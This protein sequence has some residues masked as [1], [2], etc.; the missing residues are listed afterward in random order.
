MTVTTSAKKT[1]SIL[2]LVTWGTSYL[3][4]K[5][6]SDARLNI[7][8]LLAHVLKLQ[9]IQ[10]Y[11]SFDQPLSDDEL[12]R[13]KEVLKRRCANE[14]LQYILGETEF[15]GLKFTVDRRVLIPRSDT[16][17]LVETV[18]ERMKQTLN[19]AD[20][21]QLLEIG[22]GSGCIAVSLLKLIPNAI[23]TATDISSDALEVAKT[24]VE[25]NR[26]TEKI[27]LL[28]SDFLSNTSLPQKFRCIVFNP[29]YISNEEYQLLPKEVREF[30]P[31]IALADGNDGLTFFKAFARKAASLLLDNGFAAV[32][33]AYN[34]SESVQKI[35]QESGWKN[36]STIKDYGGNFRCVVAER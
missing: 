36:I 6:F 2:D 8:L 13:F 30:E 19:N 35:F 26:V 14:P 23:V 11:T 28:Q 7:E 16:E 34:Q 4:E 25:R 17:V 22:T 33:H 9:R 1:W 3:S 15:M 27:K 31:K 21:V 24:N 32:E 20:E 12:A 10:L 5:G 29:P 18:L